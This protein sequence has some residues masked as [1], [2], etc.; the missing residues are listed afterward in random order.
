MA[1]IETKQIIE[2][3]IRQ[4]A[5]SLRELQGE[6]NACRA[7]L[8]R[9]REEH[10]TGTEAYQQR[11]AELKAAQ[12]EYNRV[13]RLSVKEIQ[14]QKKEQE[15][16]SRTAQQVI[17]SNKAVGNSYNALSVQLAKL[18]EEWKATGN[19]AKRNELGRE[20]NKVKAQLNGLDHSI[21]NWQRNVGN[22]WNTIKKGLAGLT[23]G[24]VGAIALFRKAADVF[25]NVSRST[26]A[27]G[28]ALAREVAAWKSGWDYFTKAIAS[29]DFKDFIRGATEAA[30]A[31]RR[32]AEV[33]DEVFERTNSLSLQRAD[34]LQQMTEWETIFR[35]TGKSTEER[36][37][38]IDNYIGKLKE[39]QA[40]EVETRERV[41]NATLDE[42]AASVGLQEADREEFAQNI[43]N[44]NL[45]E[46]LIK[47]AQKYNNLQDSISALESANW[48]ENENRRLEAIA[49]RRQEMEQF[50]EAEK[51]FA[52]FARA[53]NLTNDERVAAYVES[54]RALKEAGVSAY[55]EN[56]RL[57]TMRSTLQKEEAE[58][59]KE[60]VREAE[61]VAAQLAGFQDQLADQILADVQKE[62]EALNQQVSQQIKADEKRAQ[63][64]EEAAR[65][66]REATENNALAAV[67]DRQT[68]AEVTARATIDDEAA[69]AAALYEIRK[70]SNED[71]LALLR[72]FAQEAYNRGDLENW[73]AYN[74]Q[75]ADMEV[76]IAQDAETEKARIRRKGVK[77]A[78]E[79]AKREREMM[80]AT[81]AVMGNVV[82]AYQA[83]IQQR[84]EGGKI[85]EEQAEQEFKS[86]KA[87]QY[88]QTM[89]NTLA[90]MMSVWAGEGTNAMK[91]VLSASV[92]TQG[93]A[94]AMQI[95]NTTLGST[96][97]A[98]QAV[99]SA[100]VAAPVVI[101]ALPQVQAVTS[102]S[103]E[104][105]LN[106]RAADQRVYVVYSDIERAGRKTRVTE[107][108]SRF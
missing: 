26:Q 96:A 14:A 69:L 57:Y 62:G 12:T 79:Q 93:L 102:A 47:Q 27:S 76:K 104:A 37:T 34:D 24:I 30:A 52:D 3:D 4:A 16:A 43:K 106:E 75:A 80:K 21:G 90:G 19:E 108:E 82:S 39:Y 44:Y 51:E 99:T 61:R 105:V 17:Q 53:Y 36:L 48:G 33:L 42:L 98:S 58:K 60:R 28:D 45:N 85:S 78:E 25:I 91:A 49:L 70:K 65:R 101:N 7:A 13:M 40:Q 50:T 2:I 56:R 71:R 87:I 29:A 23:A 77:D 59:G 20:I 97:Q 84:V 107:G 74:K 64:A 54:E 73:V 9:M 81:A 41:R 95:S 88:A 63:S 1:N 31:G 10:Q 83:Y 89:I 67:G 15:A 11:T 100:A 55:Q 72:Q 103:Q 86:V 68:G 6:I 5:A 92:L 18:K 8:V 66:I 46:V 38:A 32:L 94:A 35:D 22:Y